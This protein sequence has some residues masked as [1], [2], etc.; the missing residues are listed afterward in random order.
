M[1]VVSY[2]GRLPFLLFFILGGNWFVTFLRGIQIQVWAKLFKNS[3]QFQF[4]WKTHDVR[5]AVLVKKATCCPRAS[6]ALFRQR[7]QLPPWLQRPWIQHGHSCCKSYI[8]I[9]C[10]IK[11]IY[12]IQPEASSCENHFLSDVWQAVW[13]FSRLSRTA[14]M[15]GILRNVS[16]QPG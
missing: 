7:G 1:A 15:F 5:S 2:L 6:P 8:K 11:A 12:A 13:S 16:L 3:F 14:C 9:T 10:R 4:M